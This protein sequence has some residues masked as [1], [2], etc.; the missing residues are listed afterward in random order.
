MKTKVKRFAFVSTATLLGILLVLAFS[1]VGNKYSGPLDSVWTSI[2]EKVTDLEHELLLSKRKSVR[3]K[4]LKWFNKYRKD[5][6]LLKN[7][8]TILLGVYDNNYQKTFDDIIN[9]DTSLRAPL[10]LIQI[11]VA[12]GDKE[13]EQFPMKYAKIIYDLGSLPMITWEPWLNDFNREKHGLPIVKDANKQGMLAVA[14]GD[15]DFYIDHW[16][17]RL[18]EF[19]RPVFI[20]LGHE[21]NDPY[22]YPW[23]P[24][25]NKPEDFV[26]AWKH[27]FNRFKKLKVN[28]ILW[29]WSPQPAYLHYKEYYPGKEY[30]NWVGVGALNYGTVAP[31]S[32]WWTFKEIFGDYYDLLNAFNKPI[33]VT[34]IGSLTVGGNREK[35]FNNAFTNLPEKYPNLKALL[36]FD[37]NSDNTT[38]NKTLNWSIVNDSLT[39]NAISTAIKKW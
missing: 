11:Y 9:L 36:F 22:R 32:K 25:N 29:I 30:V 37:D 17:N 23:G 4:K 24:Q 5:I 15:Y 12:W 10:P 13:T 21:M 31:W 16:A 35:W 34:E 38:L 26:K 28:N 33:M 19:H 1:Y 2:G 8:D 20:R 18:K 14:Q 3:S 39:C 6:S 27:V 7:P